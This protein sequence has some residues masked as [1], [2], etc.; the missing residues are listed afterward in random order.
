[1]SDPTP[2]AEPPRSVHTTTL[3]RLLSQLGV[4]LVVSTYQAGK[5]FF[6]RDENGVANTHFRAIDVPMG[7]AFDRGRLAVG[8]SAGL[9]EFHNQP[10]VGQRVDATGRTDAYFLPRYYTVSGHIAVHEVAYAGG[11]LWAVNTKFSCLCTFDRAHSFVPRWRPPFV[12]RYSATDRCHLNGF[13]FEN[14][15]PKYAT[16][17][18]T[19]DTDGGWRPDKAAGGVLMEVP[20]GRVVAGGLS[21]PHSPRLHDGKLWVC[22]SGKGSLATVDPDTG[23]LTTVALVPGFTRGLD[24]VG[25]FAFVGLSQVRETAV[26]SGIPITERLAPDERACGVWVIDTRT[27]QSVAFLRFE[28]GVREVFAVTVL[29][30]RWPDLVSDTADEAVVGSYVLPDEALAEVA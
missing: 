6:I 11:E 27:G 9:W 15:Q 20:S 16:A 8:T 19:T 1:M 25:P 23:E 14:D 17:L 13:C 18:G 26:F 7:V 28:A 24:F 29:P 2:A 5:L 10:A 4:S 22:E 21:M 30:H 12:T 3:P